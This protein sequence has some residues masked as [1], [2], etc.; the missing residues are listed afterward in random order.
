MPFKRKRKAISLIELI[1]VLVVLSIILGI[2]FLSYSDVSKAANDSIAKSNT[3]AIKLAIL[4]FQYESGGK[5]PSSIINIK[6]GKTDDAKKLRGYL[7][8]S[9]YSFPDGYNYSWIKREDKNAGVIV[10]TGGGLKSGYI[11]NVGG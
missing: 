2:S 7:D 11:V 9:D 3:K 8:V 10:V 4:L 5:L 1:I 6:T